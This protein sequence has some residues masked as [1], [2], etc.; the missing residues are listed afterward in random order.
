LDEA[1]CGKDREKQ[2]E[3]TGCVSLA[4][5]AEIR[6]VFRKCTA[7]SVGKFSSEDAEDPAFEAG[8]ALFQP[9]HSPLP[10]RKDGL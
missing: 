10:L 9:A 1:I 4:Q 6:G 2:A 7:T 5:V 3:T 8:F